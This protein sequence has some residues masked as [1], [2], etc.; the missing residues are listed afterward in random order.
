MDVHRP[1]SLRTCCSIA[2]GAIGGVGDER[3]LTMTAPAAVRS[4]V[5]TTTYRHCFFGL[6]LFIEKD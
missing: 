2:L 5:P 4:N 1:G 3:L 6:K